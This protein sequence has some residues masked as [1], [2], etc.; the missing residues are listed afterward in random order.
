MIQHKPYREYFSKYNI[1]ITH[2]FIGITLMRSIVI[3]RDEKTDKILWQGPNVS[4]RVIESL[5]EKSLKEG[6][7]ILLDEIELTKKHIK[8]L[9]GNYSKGE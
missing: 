4:Q 9:E 7:N 1:S 8:R 3:I 2:H 5:I 6:K